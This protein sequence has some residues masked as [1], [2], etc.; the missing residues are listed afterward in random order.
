[1]RNKILDRSSQFIWDKACRDDP[2][3]LLELGQYLG[4]FH[5][6]AKQTYLHLRDD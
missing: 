4:I 2:A 1:M 3:T 6:E 5:P